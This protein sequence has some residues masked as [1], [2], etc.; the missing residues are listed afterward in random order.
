MARL[1][2]APTLRPSEST[3]PSASQAS[4]RRPRPCLRGE[5]LQ[6]R[7]RRRV[8]EDVDRQDAGGALADRGR[9]GR[10]I[11]VERLGVDVAEDRPR[12]LVE[13]AV[14]RGDEAEGAG[15][16]LVAGAPAERPHAEVQRRRC[17]W[18]PRPRPRPRASRRTRA[19]SARPSAPAR[20]GP[21][22]STSST[23]SS[24]RAPISGLASGIGSMSARP[25]RLSHASSR[26]WKAYSSESTSASQEASMMFSETPIVPH[27]RSPS[28]E[29]SRTRVTAPVPWSSSRIRTL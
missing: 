26:G 22:R 25:R 5:R 21:E 13:Q 28:E 12:A 9:G 29:S 15:Q 6:L 3:A 24:S 27:S 11:E 20:A 14:G 7:H 2:R 8:A 16:D 19:R 10:G 17:R 4:S 18:R 23:S 1:P